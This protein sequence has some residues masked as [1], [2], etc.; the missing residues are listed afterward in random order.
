MSNETGE[1][2]FKTLVAAFRNDPEAVSFFVQL[3]QVADTLDDLVDGEPWS[4]ASVRRLVWDCL[5]SIQENRFFSEH[6]DALTPVMASAFLAWEDSISL[7]MTGGEEEVLTAHVLRY[8]ILDVAVMC[9]LIIG[10]KEWA[11]MV[12]PELRM[13][14]RDDT[15]KQFLK[16]MKDEEDTNGVDA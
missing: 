15:F 10:G 9:A 6:R 4:S 16:E 8:A 7:A 11:N 3:C 13:A 1:K 14:C 2:A 12:G 5:F